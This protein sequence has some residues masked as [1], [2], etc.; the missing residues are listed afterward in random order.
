M[1]IDKE[2]MI[3]RTLKVLVTVALSAFTTALNLIYNRGVKDASFAVEINQLKSQNERLE[4]KYEVLDKAFA[5]FVA[6]SNEKRRKQ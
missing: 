3:E 1:T 5:E 2:K 6:S 4:G